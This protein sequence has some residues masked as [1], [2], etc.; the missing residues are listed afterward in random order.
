MTVEYRRAVPSDIATCI[1]LRGKTRENAVSVERLAQLG[2][3]LASWSAGVASG[4]LL[5]Y[6]CLEHGQIVGY[7]FADKRRGEIVVLVVMPA[8]EGKGI[9]KNLLDLMVTDFA[10]LGFQTLFLACSLDPKVRS[11]GFYR[12]LGWKSTSTFDSNHDEVLEF[13]VRVPA[14]GSSPHP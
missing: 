12:H 5:G 14:R 10:K 13:V 11:Y 3:T 1:A 8:W 7:C 6:V 2:V 9:G 4:D